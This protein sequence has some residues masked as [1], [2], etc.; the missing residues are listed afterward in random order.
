MEAVSYDNKG[1][2]NYDNFL[3]FALDAVESDDIIEIHEKIHKEV[4]TRLKLRF[5][6]VLKLFSSSK[7]YENGYVRTSE[8]EKVLKKMSS[9]ITTKDLEF[10]VGYWDKEQEVLSL[11]FSLSLSLSTLLLL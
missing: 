3:L 9:R 4:F 7:T 5:K 2:I 1:T 8:F 6:D 11:S 10:L